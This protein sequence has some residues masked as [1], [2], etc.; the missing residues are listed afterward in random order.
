MNRERKL[1]DC[2]KLED[3][4]VIDPRKKIAVSTIK[5]LNFTVKLSVRFQHFWTAWEH[6]R[7]ES[8]E[9]TVFWKLGG[10][11]NKMTKVVNFLNVDETPTVWNIQNYE[12]DRPLQ[13]Q[14]NRRHWVSSSVSVKNNVTNSLNVVGKHSTSFDVI[15]TE[16]SCLW[17]HWRQLLF[18][19]F[20]ATNTNHSEYKTNPGCGSNWS[21]DWYIC[22]DWC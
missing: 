21:I 9:A 3:N 22:M 1:E 17:W 18:N 2:N 7:L 15:S 12:A 14:W 10:T 16:M 13:H 8:D 6:R 4:I 20:T 5:F 19:K 11:L